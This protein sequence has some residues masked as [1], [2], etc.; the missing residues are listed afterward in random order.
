MV[1]N[2][3]MRGRN[4]NNNRKRKIKYLDNKGGNL[5]PQ[6]SP[7]Y[8]GQTPNFNDGA[9]LPNEPDYTGSTH[10]C[11]EPGWGCQDPGWTCRACFGSSFGTCYP[12]GYDCP[13]VTIPDPIP[14]TCWCWCADYE[15]QWDYI[16]GVWNAVQCTEPGSGSGGP[17]WVCNEDGHCQGTSDCRGI[18]EQFGCGQ[19]YPSNWWFEGVVPPYDD[20]LWECGFS[21]AP[22]SI[23]SE[24]AY[25]DDC[26]QCNGSITDC[27]SQCPWTGNSAGWIDSV[28]N[29]T[30][31]SCDTGG[32]ASWCDD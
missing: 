20:G 2:G 11:F 30:F 3:K 32:G 16:P 19:L 22:P 14:S 10:S 17:E 1:E 13:N 27:D 28:S 9:Q 8:K 23:P 7:L 21:N 25:Y 24:C 26:G 5:R 15:G 6:G 31:G 18:C 12:P 29:C 4:S